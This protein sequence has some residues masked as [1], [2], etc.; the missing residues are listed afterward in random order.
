M[1]R[2]LDYNPATGVKEIFHHDDITG[3]WAIE[4]QQDVSAQLEAA[5]DMRND[6]E[7][8]KQGIKNGNWHYAH[9]TDLVMYKMINE[10]GVN[11]LDPNNTTKVG[12][13]IDSKYEYCK[14]T[15]GHHKFHS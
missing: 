8:T 1:K 14:V 13:L 12:Q 6:P 5:K 4:T 11:P 9:L 7:N 3:E 15:N 2:L 10:D